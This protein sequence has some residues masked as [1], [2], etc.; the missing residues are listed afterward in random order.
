MSIVVAVAF[1][2]LLAALAVF[3]VALIAGAPLGAYAWGGQDRVLPAKKRMGSVISILLYVLFAA[4]A[5][6]R[7]GL[8]DLLA[9][10]SILVVAMWIVFGY[11]VLGIVLNAL[12]RS[13]R[14]RAVMT[15]LVLVLAALAL[16][17][18]LT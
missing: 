5:L 10:S 3:Q 1:C 18:A 2:T 12:S 16:I 13:T 9:P 11:L 8:I 15:P 14:E 6:G 7:V 17:I 4:I